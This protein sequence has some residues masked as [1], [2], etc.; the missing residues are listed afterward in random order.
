MRG[1]GSWVS[2]RGW[3]QLFPA[4]WALVTLP[5]ACVLLA[6]PC[7]QLGYPVSARWAPQFWG[8]CPFNSCPG[9]CLALLGTARARPPNRARAPAGP[10]PL[11]PAPARAARA[12]AG[13][14]RRYCCRPRGAS[15]PPAARGPGEGR[16]QPRSG[17]GLPPLPPHASRE[18][19]P[20]ALCPAAPGAPPRRGESCGRGGG[21]GG[22]ARGGMCRAGGRGAGVPVCTTRRGPAGRGS[23]DHVLFVPRRRREVPGPGRPSVGWTGGHCPHGRPERPGRGPV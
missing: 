16:G 15:P 22:D 3:P 19:C 13:R 6:L 20:F 4:F 17:P 12:G 7:P 23:R 8:H 10:P 5:S 18:V 9:R 1:S 2:Y 11:A 14:W 21:E